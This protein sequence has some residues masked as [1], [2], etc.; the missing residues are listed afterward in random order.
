MLVMKEVPM[1]YQDD[2]ES[3]EPPRRERPRKRQTAG[4]SAALE[5]PA[6]VAPVATGIDRLIELEEQ[7]ESRE[8]WAAFSA[9]CSALG[10]LIFLGLGIYLAWKFWVGFTA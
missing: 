1:P 2:Y 5:V 8:K 9:A 3:V 7:R 10:W 6:V 4:S